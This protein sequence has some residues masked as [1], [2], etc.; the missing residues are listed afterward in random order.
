VLAA[1]VAVV[2]AACGNDSDSGDDADTGGS[3]DT[4]AAPTGEPIK[5]LSMSAFTGIQ[6]AEAPVS[7]DPVEAHAQALNDAGGI[8]GRPVE[9]IACDTGNDAVKEIGCARQAVD[10]GVAAVVGVLTADATDEFELFEANGIPAIGTD[11]T[12]SVQQTNPVSFPLD[13]GGA[14]QVAGM[15]AILAD[16]GATKVSAIVPDITGSALDELS[17]TWSDSA[18]AHGLDDVGFVPTSLDVT[19]PT[20]VVTTATAGGVDGVGLILVGDVFARVLQALQQQHPEIPVALNGGLVDNEVLQAAGD[21]AEGAFVVNNYPPTTATE[22]EGI[23]TMLD[24]MEAFG[25]DTTNI[26]G[27]TIKFWLA[28]YVF[29]EVAKQI[30]DGGGTVDAA[31]MLDALNGETDLDTLGLTPPLN[32]SEPS[33]V[34]P[35]AP[36]IFNATVVVTVVEGGEQ[37][38]VDPENPLLDPFET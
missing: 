14:G 2:A 26:T 23:Q 30:A 37:K 6:G 24:E 34:V 32:F 31:S 25:A 5:I 9:V 20:P 27:D 38:L 7:P 15:P 28:T 4:A 33:D 10:E 35:D 22:I 8:G 16:E 11:T 18:E 19:D 12:D 17:Q 1:V 13:S 36:R 29:G 21:N 3:G